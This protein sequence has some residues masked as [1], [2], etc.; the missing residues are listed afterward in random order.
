MLPTLGKETK[1]L[2]KLVDGLRSAIQSAGADQ[3]KQVKEELQKAI[4]SIQNK[5]G[6]VEDLFI[7]KLD[8]WAEMLN[9]D[10]LVIKGLKVLA[11]EETMDFLRKLMKGWKDFQKG[12]THITMHYR[13]FVVG[14]LSTIIATAFVFTWIGTMI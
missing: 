7:K 12:E 10:P 11:R 1:G 14:W 9:A 2:K 6:T 4:V 13:T 8:D 5:E 3:V